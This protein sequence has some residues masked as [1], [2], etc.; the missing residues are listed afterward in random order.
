M[1]E[2]KSKQTTVFEYSDLE[3]LVSEVYGT[4]IHILQDEDF[5]PWE[6]RGHYTYHTWTVDGESGLGIVGDDDIVRKWIET[7][8]MKNLDMSDVPV[9]D[10][11]DTAAVGLEHIM[12]R[13]FR[14]GYIPA[15][16][17]LMKVDW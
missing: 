16:E 17:Y 4:E 10:W 5:I 7:G 15:G 8:Q 6:R 9:F 3:K 12:H 2:L 13:L 14:D 11:A 1:P